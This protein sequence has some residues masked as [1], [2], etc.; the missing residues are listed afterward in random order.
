MNNLNKK[1]IGFDSWTGGISHFQR[2]ITPLKLKKIDFTLVHISSWGGYEFKKESYIEDVLC[3]DISF[4]KNS[5]FENVF[6]EEKP[7]AVI[8]L[9][10]DVF[11]HRAFI[12][13]CKKLSIPTLN[14]YHGLHGVMN[15]DNKFSI[16]KSGN[17]NLISHIVS[18]APNLL[19]YKIPAYLLSLKRTDAHFKDW[20]QFLKDCYFLAIG[21]IPTLTNA[22][23]DSLTD[24]YA[25]YTN[26][27]IEYTLKRYKTDLNNISVVGNPDLYAFGFKSSY[28]R[29]WKLPKKER[30]KI[31]Y[32]ET[33]YYDVSLVYDGLDDFVD[34]ILETSK[35]L[36]TLGYDLIL[37][38]K[39]NQIS[40]TA[41]TEKLI[42]NNIKMVKNNS[43]FKTLYECHACIT[44]A[45]SLSL[46]PALMG[47]PLILPKYG[48]LKDLEYGHILNTYPKSYQLYKIL[49]LEAILKKDKKVDN[50]ND[51]IKWVNEYL[52]PVP[53]NKMPERVVSIIEKM[54]GC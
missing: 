32:I 51:I 35:N 53:F 1:I 26:S 41:I 50:E 20:I 14:L 28:V 15:T 54:R 47:M 21:G 2:L 40:T 49:D 31:L 36:E 48:R 11:A 6:I 39:P 34:H 42:K 12:R 7:A 23:K 30:K 10:T 17:S 45:S 27:E 24:E 43:F 29:S 19:K 4:Y 33:G 8:F 22:A 16:P 46:I 25:V 52:G 13:Y 5:N 38:L 44:E 3:R 37:K 18:K 9:S